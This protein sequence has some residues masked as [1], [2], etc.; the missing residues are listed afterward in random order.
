LFPVGNNGEVQS[1]HFNR[2]TNFQEFLEGIVGSI[3]DVIES[4]DVKIYGDEEYSDDTHYSIV[5]KKYGPHNLLVGQFTTLNK[6]EAESITDWEKCPYK[7]KKLNNGFV[8]AYSDEEFITVEKF[9]EFF[10][11]LKDR[12]I[13]V[14]E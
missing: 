8:F 7:T 6:E 1:F 4:L 10:E 5:E 9:M 12:G 2:G 11:F 13:K 3:C 14:W